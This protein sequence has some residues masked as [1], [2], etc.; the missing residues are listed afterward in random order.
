MAVTFD[1]LLPAIV[2]AG[3]AGLSL[4]KIRTTFGGKAAAK[5]VTP[6]L[7]EKLATLAHEGAIWGPL[8]QG[9]AQLYFA[10]GRGPSIE[11]ASRAIVTLVASSGVKLISKPGLGKKVTGM[12]K[13][14]FPDGLKHAVSSQ[15]I[16]ELT[17]GSSKY[18]LHRD[19]AAE[20]FGFEPA[21][22]G[23]IAPASGGRDVTAAASLTLDDVLPAYRRL[24]AEQGGFSAV[25]IYDLMKA[26][27]GSKEELHRLLIDE[28]KAGRV[29]IHPTTTVDLPKEEMEA[30]IR[31]AGF[32]EPFV[33]VVVKNDP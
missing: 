18:Y 22:Q 16:V 13:K 15:A 2:K 10:R 11:T 5:K 24:K 3:D 27:N 25:K 33:T 29:T 20:Y 30:G 28:T 9:V 8:K 12:N 32:P 19:V 4:A 31:L 26:L 17:C 1:D 6:E 7:R 14:F 21:E 23:R